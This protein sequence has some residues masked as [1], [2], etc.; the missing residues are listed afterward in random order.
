[1][2][3][4]Q[5]L[6]LFLFLFCFVSKTEAV[7][8]GNTPIMQNRACCCLLQKHFVKMIHLNSRGNNYM[9]LSTARNPG[10]LTQR[11]EGGYQVLGLHR[12]NAECEL[13]HW[14]L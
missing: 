13:Q 7:C 14:Y 9:T 4:D 2:E 1:M 12:K 11:K 3:V 6:M 5:S 8:T 10:V